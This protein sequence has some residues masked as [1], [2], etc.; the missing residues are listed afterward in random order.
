MTHVPQTS[1]TGARRGAAEVLWLPHIGVMIFIV[2][3][4]TLLWSTAWWIYV[5]GAP[6]VI[7]GWKDVSETCWL[8]ILEAR[9]R[10]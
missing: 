2:I 5:L 9:L 6:C 8:S 7:G 10:G 3:G 4:W 1:A